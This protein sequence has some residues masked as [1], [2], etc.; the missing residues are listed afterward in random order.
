[1]NGIVLKKVR[2]H[3]LK[4]IDVT[5]RYGSLVVVTGVSGSGKSSLA[6]DT[7]YAEGRR[8]YVE[9]LSA[10]A[11]QFL[12]RI[13][14][15]D[16]DSVTGILPSIAIEAKNAISN[17][18][19]TVGTQTEL[20]DYLRLLFARVGVTRCTS[21]GELVEADSPASIAQK[22]NQEF[23]RQEL[24]VAFP[25]GLGEQIRRFS[26]EARDELERQGFLHFLVAGKRASL[27]ELAS[28]IRKGETN[29]LVI[30]DELT[31]TD[32]VRSRLLDSLESALQFGKGKVTVLIQGKNKQTAL[33]FSN[34]FHCGPCNLIYR[35]PHPNMFSF[36]SPLGACP[37]CQGFGR[38]I[39]IDWDLV[40][41][42]RN[43]SLEEGAIEPWTKPSASWEKRQ[44]K[45]FCVR[46]KIPLT[47]PFSKLSEQHKSWIVNG[48]KGDKY[49]S[50]QDFFKYLQ[51]KTYKMHVRIFLSK[52]RAYVPCTKCGGARLKR[53]ALAVRVNQKNMAELSILNLESLK[54]LFDTLPLT[55]HEYAIAE[56]LLA[57]I[58]NRLTFLVEVGL[59]YLSLDRL[60]RTLS[61]G[62]SQRIRLAASLGSQLVDTL[63]V[64]DE[65][66]IGLHE[67]DHK[68]LIGLLMKLK[69]L[70]NTIVV[71]EH[72]RT[73]IESADQVI[74]LGPKS[75]ERGGRIVYSGSFDKMLKH[76]DS[77]T[78]RYFRNELRVER[79]QTQ[80]NYAARTIQI[81]RASEHNLK[82]ISVEIPLRKF[83]VI[84][85]V[86][87]SGKST[88]M[89]D[90][91][92]ANYL[93][94]R[95]RKVQEVGKVQKIEGWNSIEDILLID[96]SP[97]GRTP[98]SNPVT[99][100]KAFD[101][102]RKLFA[103]TR[104]A[105]AK[106]FEPGH[107]SFNTPGGRCSQCQGDGVQK[108]EMHFLADVHMTCDACQGSRYQSSV[109]AIRY[110][111]KNIQDVL[112]MTVDQALTFFERERRVCQPLY[113]LSQVGLGHLRLGQS[114]TT[115]SGGE[116]QRL[117]LASELARS[118]KDNLL[119]LFD[120]PTTGL[121]Y[122]DIAALVSAFE[123]L[124]T[125]GHSICLIEHNMEVIK[126]ADYVIDLGPE[127]GD[128]GGNVV[129][130]GPLEG[131][132]SI[133]QSHT[134][135]ALKRYQSLY[136]TLN[137]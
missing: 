118:P 132:L 85:G 68:L 6:F 91:L 109:L 63:Y 12:E 78:A 120:E 80:P 98:R 31:L 106:H 75:G 22:V 62:E 14:K 101:S 114:A 48:L 104:E 95:G 87:G 137:V 121:H 89:Y 55:K 72:D 29:I 115:L 4:A 34:Q 25:L 79:T 57:E 97:I 73:M 45:K 53:E 44:L 26:K 54:S 130:S 15:P 36:N 133:K 71:V 28:Y 47:R 124:L 131:M 81:H 103:S 83:S 99:Y 52:Y 58:R 82:N 127:G 93:R 41:P 38:V 102:I 70:G 42:N 43:L 107:F 128:Q 1:M 32:C 59:G 8:R 64:L 126:C 66:S 90:V 74:D 39:T 9:S 134:G 51:K 30:Q 135:A 112:E 105:K 119:Y 129:Y 10:Y 49:F 27:K 117:K 122:Y 100:M 7:L 125:R 13:E 40:I 19:S 23:K 92:Y 136:G 35:T 21:C 56:P 60:S 65:P 3:N 88:L 17:A 96:Q 33:S 37:E 46:K 110:Q 50:I 20:N 94:W 77:Y 2:T 116:A 123:T 67:R 111:G 86:S 18:R 76:K 113:V 24:M 84:T 5:I 11:R 108:V 69:A 61:G 16:L